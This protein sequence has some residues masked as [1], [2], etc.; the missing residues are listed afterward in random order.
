[1]EE[2]QIKGW[3]YYGLI[4]VLAVAVT[5]FVMRDAISIMANTWWVSATFNHVL[6][7]LPVFFWLIWQR[8]SALAQITPQPFAWG[9]LALLMATGIWFAGFVADVMVVQQFGFIFTL[10]AITLAILGRA[11]FHAL[12]FPMLYMIFLIPFGEGLIP[13]LQDLTAVAIVKGLQLVNVPVYVDGT[14]LLTPSGQFTVAEACSGVRYLISTVALGALFAN[15]AFKSWKR[16]LAIMVVSIAMPIVANAIRAFGI[17][18]IAYLTDN[19]YAAGVDHIIYGWVFFAVVTLALLLIGMSFSDR[20]V[21]DPPVDLGKILGRYKAS[22]RQSSAVSIAAVAIAILGITALYAQ[23]I[24][25]RGPDKELTAF[26]NITPPDGWENVDIE[27]AGWFPVYLNADVERMDHFGKGRSLISLYRVRYNTQDDKR[28]LI[29]YGNTV[30]A[31]DEHWTKTGTSR[32]K[33]Q[34]GGQEVEIAAT[35]LNAANGVIRD[36]WQVFWVNDNVVASDLEGK[37]Q[38]VF[39]RLFAGE[40]AVGSVVISTPR[41]GA[42]TSTDKAMRDFI[43][44]LPN[45]DVLLNTPP[46]VLAEQGE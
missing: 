29:R 6:L 39:A 36:V 37:L 28:E 41:L 40:L 5:A 31:P 21:E 19:A 27:S 38:S 12:L 45:V 13:P 1:M 8:K 20:P 34:W 44:K 26:A 17:V 15:I 2:S 11:V 30:I 43:A 18:Y 46:T 42:A 24:Q 32:H 3:R 10:Q 9:L 25:S 35:Q 22:L 14:L 16:R 23:Y 4:W 33:V 7:I